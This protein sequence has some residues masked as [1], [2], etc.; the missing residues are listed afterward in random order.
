MVTLRSGKSYAGDNQRGSRP[1]RRRQARR[2]A[3]RAYVRNVVARLGEVHVE[4]TVNTN[5]ITLGALAQTNVLQTLDKGTDEADRAGKEI[6]LKGFALKWFLNNKF[7][8]AGSTS[9]NSY[10]WFRMAIVIDKQPMQ[11]S[12]G[13]KM[14]I[15]E[16]DVNLKVDYPAG[17]RQ[18]M[19]RKLNP[20]RYKVLHQM[21]IKLGPNNVNSNI[22]NTKVINRY[23]PINRKIKFENDYATDASGISPKIRLLYW[24]GKPETDTVEIA[25]FIGQNYIIQ[26]KFKDL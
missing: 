26:E 12:L 3:T 16:A 17:A 15:S 18:N 11:A 14:F 4:N 21:L 1:R 13:T 20:E 8:A 23:F 5:D 24:S 2:P 19:I 22:P 9:P 7:T 6:Y 25:N 10:V